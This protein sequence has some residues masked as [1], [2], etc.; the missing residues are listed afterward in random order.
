MVDG[1]DHGQVEWPSV[2]EEDGL[3]FGLWGNYGRAGKSHYHDWE[4]V[5]DRN[6]G[7][8]ALGICCGAWA[9]ASM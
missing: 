1:H 2:P 9:T 3:L 4:D 6:S 5:A 8:Y 7:D